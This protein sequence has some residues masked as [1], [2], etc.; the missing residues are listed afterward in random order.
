MSEMWPWIALT[1]GSVAV[2]LLSYTRQWRAGELVFK[3]LASTGFIATA[4]AAGAL[5]SPYG[6]W[7][8]AALVA[9]MAGDVFL[10]GRSKQ[11]FLAGLVAFLVGHVLY[12]VAFAVRGLSVEWALFGALP[13]LALTSLIARWLLPHV[14]PRMKTPVVVY[15]TAFTVMVSM[16]AGTVGAERRWLILIG[17][18]GFMLSDIAVARNRF[19]RPGLVNR[20]WGIPLYFGAQLALASTV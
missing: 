13:T 5:D 8:L 11:L 16:A 12:I 19:V 10:M 17:S 18:V 1:G 3:P 6:N 15:M 20:L 9:G 2:L 14:E 4:F 7:V